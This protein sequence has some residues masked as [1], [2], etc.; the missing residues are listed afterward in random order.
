MAARLTLL[1]NKVTYSHDGRLS[2]AV[3]SLVAPF[4]M[5]NR[6]PTKYGVMHPAP[7]LS[8]PEVPLGDA[9]PDRRYLL[10]S[11]APQFWLF[12]MGLFLV[13]LALVGRERLVGGVRGLFTRASTRTGP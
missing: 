7:R 12:W 2:V 10:S 3:A 6:K 11:S 1:H 9:D 4:E 5:V 8:L 13:V